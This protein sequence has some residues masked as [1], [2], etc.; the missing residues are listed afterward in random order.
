[1]EKHIG[2]Y[3]ATARMMRAFFWPNGG[4]EVTNANLRHIAS[5]YYYVSALRRV[6]ALLPP[7]LSICTRS[8]N[9]QG[10][11]FTVNLQPPLGGFFFLHLDKMTLNDDHTI[12]ARSLKT[13]PE[14]KVPLLQFSPHP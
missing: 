2:A 10:R 14:S 8:L 12:F 13:F 3:H 9:T 7:S 11:L 5:R 4:A 1:M 6:R